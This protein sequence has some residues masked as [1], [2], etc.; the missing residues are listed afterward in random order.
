M[1]T[2]F[3]LLLKLLSVDTICSLIA[4]AIARLL[5]TASKKGGKM[6]DKVKA[7]I[8]QINKWT[9]LFLQVYDDD[10]LTEEEEKI[11]ANAIKNETPVGNI[12]ELIKK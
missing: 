11:I 6:W 9:S 2:I 8:V 3:S 12:S 1:S 10:N 4:R 7:V 5:T